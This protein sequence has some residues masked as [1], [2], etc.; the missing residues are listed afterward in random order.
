MSALLLRDCIRHERVDVSRRNGPRFERGFDA[1]LLVLCTTS[2]LLIL[3]LGAA[4][5][6]E[7]N[8]RRVLELRL[9]LLSAL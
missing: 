6:D 7:N 1:R 3:A 8:R 2:P 4:V 5:S 9:L